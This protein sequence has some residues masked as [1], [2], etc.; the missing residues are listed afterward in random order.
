[1]NGFEPRIRVYCCLWC[2]F[3]VA[4][5]AGDMQTAYS[6]NVKVNLLSCLGEIQVDDF[7][8]DF[9]E[10]NDGICLI[11]CKE[12]KCHNE[13]GSRR[14]RMRT[15]YAKHLVEGMGISKERIAVY[16]LTVSEMTRSAAII[17]E[18]KERTKKLGPI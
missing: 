9:E 5:L 17:E 3:P 11:G 2:N 8:R 10:G 4:G 1:M 16:S 14:A 18:V 15:E 12:D 13:T 7:L 6:P